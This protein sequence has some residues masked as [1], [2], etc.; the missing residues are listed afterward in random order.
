M[1][2]PLLKLL[3]LTRQS[4]E[5]GTVEPQWN[6]L[7]SFHDRRRRLSMVPRY[8]K[9]YSRVGVKLVQ[10][11]SYFNLNKNLWAPHTCAYATLQQS[12]A[13]LTFHNVAF[14]FATAILK[15]DTFSS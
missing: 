9:Y 2:L 12:V 8:H 15:F 3:L 10:T 5:H 7:P 1:P 11:E 13:N 14:N 4:A 6:E